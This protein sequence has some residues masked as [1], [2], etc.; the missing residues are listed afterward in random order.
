MFFTILLKNI[1]LILASNAT[2]S[3]NSVV[4]KPD[5]E[6]FNEHYAKYMNFKE[7]RN[8]FLCHLE[9]D[10]LRFLKKLANEEALTRIENLYSQNFD[11]DYIKT[12]NLDLYRVDE[13]KVLF[14]IVLILRD[15][16]FFIKTIAEFLKLT[17]F[18]LKFVED[19]YLL[20]KNI[21]NFMIKVKNAFTKLTALQKKY[22]KY[23][24][25]LLVCEV[26]L[27]F[28]ED[29]YI[30]R[31]NSYIMDETFKIFKKIEENVNEYISQRRKVDMVKY[32]DIEI[33]RQR[34]AENECMAVF[35]KVN[36]DE[37]LKVSKE[38]TFETNQAIEIIIQSRRFKT[39]L[40]VIENRRLLYKIGISALEYCEYWLDE[41]SRNPAIRKDKENH[42][43]IAF[44]IALNAHENF[45]QLGKVLEKSRQDP[46]NE[47]IE[48]IPN[49]ECSNC[50]CGST[51]YCD[52]ENC[53]CFGYNSNNY[54]SSF[55][56]ECCVCLK[57][58]YCG[59]S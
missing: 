57:C 59:F 27:C 22:D 43:N 10:I 2:E 53:D 3:E 21:S 7:F 36:L 37:D 24:C 29:G 19:N 38:M 58:E 30:Y 23:E 48:D 26:F 6:T 39:E 1:P 49:C 25:V 16:N 42:I 33:I 50:Y 8:N 12:H 55:G 54:N 51:G 35:D 5:E 41:I 4:I 17:E 14:G 9:E 18:A 20:N 34:F 32:E 44:C 52:S 40:E 28:A 45:F 11:S 15:L 56:D 13:R 46:I 47:P 31:T